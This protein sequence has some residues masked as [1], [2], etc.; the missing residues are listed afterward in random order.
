MIAAVNQ[1]LEET[2]ATIAK[3]APE[4]R[5]ERVS[6]VT[7]GEVSFVLLPD[8]P[9]APPEPKVEAR[10]MNPLDDPN[11]YGLPEGTKPPGFRDPRRK[12]ES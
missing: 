12:A 1:N 7:V 6:T 3:M 8:E 10:P 5:R 11:T 2:L 4:L 9:E